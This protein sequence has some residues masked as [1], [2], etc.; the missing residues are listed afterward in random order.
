M[1]RLVLL[2]MVTLVAFTGCSEN[3]GY[4]D[5][6]GY[7]GPSPSGGEGPATAGFEGGEAAPPPAE[8]APVEP[9]NGAGAGLLTAGSWDDNVFYEHYLKYQQSAQTDHERL[10]TDRIVIEVKDAEGAPISD[11]V[12]TV[13]ATGQSDAFTI[14]TVA[15]GRALFF[16]STDGEAES[17]TVT[18]TTDEDQF[19][20]T[21]FG[22]DATWSVTLEASRAVRH[23]TIDVAFVIDA[24]GSMGDEIE[25]LKSEAQWLIDQ[26][27]STYPELTVRLAT[28]AYRDQ[29]DEYVTQ[30]HDFTTD[31][32]RFMSRLRTIVASG[33]GDYPEAMGE[34]MAAAV[35]LEWSEGSAMRLA[36]VLADAPPQLQRQETTAAAARLARQKGIRLYPIGASGVADEAELVMREMAQHTLGR[37]LFLTDDS[38]IGNSHAEPHIPCYHVQRLNG[39][40]LEV[41]E[42]N[43]EGDWTTPAAEDI[44]RSVG[45]DHDGQCLAPV[46]EDDDVPVEAEPVDSPDAL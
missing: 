26:V 31:E 39:L 5:S 14:R 44:V 25:Y 30:V 20:D 16:P 28:V 27:K 45:Y 38:G 7:Y 41:I 24:T 29:G 36:F 10:P 23:Q 9:G 2:S 13:R 40:M 17:Y 18:V 22:E 32:D 8:M 46:T 37:Y 12:V 1:N 42:S 3:M 19:E 34:A 35:R 21:Y 4:G 33:G 15:D 11:G 43:L 6:D